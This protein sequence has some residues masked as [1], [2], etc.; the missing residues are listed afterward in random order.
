MLPLH[1]ILQKYNLKP[2]GVIHVG[3]HWAEEHDE[4]LKDGIE[5]FVYIEPCK[6]A[7]ITMVKK[8]STVNDVE[9]EKVKH[10]LG[11]SL[12]LNGGIT[13]MNIACGSEKKE[14]VMYVS[15][16]NQGQS[17]SLLQP[18]LH[19]HQHPEVQF[20]EAEAVRVIPLDDLSINKEGYDMLA[21]DV[22]GYEGEVLKGATET[23]KHIDIVYTEVNRGE[24]YKGNAL[25]EELDE[26]LADFE[27][28][29]THWPSPNWTW[30]DAIYIRKTLL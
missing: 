8:F 4:Y 7:F 12:T 22:Q 10:V 1:H 16:A 26:L 19:L 3:A 25:I 18:S 20:T 14:D 9:Y 2:K 11:I 5:R 21:M 13:L 24:T 29:E 28:V 23:L 30:G 6:D 27:R 17:N 15:H